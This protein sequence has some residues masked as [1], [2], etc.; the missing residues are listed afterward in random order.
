MSGKWP[1]VAVAEADRRAPPPAPPSTCRGAAA[2]VLAMRH[3][4]NSRGAADP[5]APTRPHPHVGE[6][7][8]ANMVDLMAPRVLGSFPA[9]GLMSSMAVSSTAPSGAVR[10]ISPLACASAPYVVALSFSLWWWVQG[11]DGAYGRFQAPAHRGVRRPMPTQQQAGG[12]TDDAVLDHL[13]GRPVRA[14]PQ[15]SCQADRFL[16]PPA[17]CPDV[18]A[19]VMWRPCRNSQCRRV[20]RVS[21][22]SSRY[23]GRCRIPQRCGRQEIVADVVAIGIRTSR[24]VPCPGWLVMSSRPPRASTRSVSPMSPDPPAGSAPPIPSSRIES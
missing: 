10:S 18:F 3:G 14:S 15:S 16:V 17:A 11:E 24:V 13:D 9:I 22:T 4:R 12:K 1:T 20:D 7:A 23:R 5:A 19:G 2:V 8:L 21:T 6:S